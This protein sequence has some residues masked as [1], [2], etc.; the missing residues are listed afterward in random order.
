MTRLRSRDTRA[1]FG[2][3]IAARLAAAH[4]TRQVQSLDVG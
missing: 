3:A 1:S 2:A 4:R